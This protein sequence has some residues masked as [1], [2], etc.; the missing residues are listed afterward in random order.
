MHA[1][2][3]SQ[4]YEIYKLIIVYMMMNSTINVGTCL[5]NTSVHS[6]ENCHFS[7][8]GIFT[9]SNSHIS[10]LFYPN[11]HCY[12]L[13]QIVSISFLYRYKV[14]Q[15]LKTYYTF[16]ILNLEWA[17]KIQMIMSFIPLLKTLSYLC[18]ARIM[19]KLFIKPPSP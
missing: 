9:C 16:F 3:T 8:W 13:V 1:H 17:Y 4:L 15:L 12:Y 2:F 7:Y 5:Y 18:V 11:N 6:M 14:S 10:L 19:S